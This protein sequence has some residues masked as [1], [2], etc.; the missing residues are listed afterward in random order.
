MASRV[1][2][3]G[4]VAMFAIEPFGPKRKAHLEIYLN[5]LRK[6]RTPETKVV[7][8]MPHPIAVGAIAYVSVIMKEE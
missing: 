2:Y 7:V 3:V 5:M 4:T 1:A 8:R 6:S